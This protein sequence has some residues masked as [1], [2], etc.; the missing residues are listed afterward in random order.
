M[1]IILEFYTRLN[2]QTKNHEIWDSAHNDTEKI[3][4]LKCYIT[5]NEE[6]KKI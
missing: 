1:K 5:N 4:I 6:R 2:S 3:K